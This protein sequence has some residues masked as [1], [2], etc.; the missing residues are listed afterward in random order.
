[1]ASR[2][3]AWDG[4]VQFPSDSE[5]DEDIETTSEKEKKEIK[6]EKTKRTEV[7]EEEK[8]EKEKKKERKM[9]TPE[10]QNEETDNE[11]P[12]KEKKK[13][14]K[15]EKVEKQNEET[16][17]EKPE[18]EKKKKEKIT[19]KTEKQNKETEKEKLE[20]EKKKA[21]KTEKPEEQD[22]GEKEK[23]EKEK[24]KKEKKVENQN[25]VTGKAKTEKEKMKTSA[26]VQ[27]VPDDLK[28]AIETIVYNRLFPDLMVLFTNRFCVE[29]ASIVMGRSAQE[30]ILNRKSEVHKKF[31]EFCISR[32]CVDEIDCLDALM[33]LLDYKNDYD[34]F[35]NRFHGIWEAYFNHDGKVNLDDEIF[36]VLKKHHDIYGDMDDKKETPEKLKTEKKKE[37]P[38]K[39]K[40]AKEKKPEKLENQHEETGKAKKEKEKDDDDDEK[41]DKKK[42]KED[43]GKKEKKAE[44]PENGD[45]EKKKT[46]APDDLLRAID[47]VIHDNLVPVLADKFPSFADGNKRVA[48]GETFEECMVRTHEDK[49]LKKELIEFYE[50]RKCGNELACLYAL[51][52]L[53]EDDKDNSDAFING[54]HAIWEKFF[55][56]GLEIGRNQ[57]LDACHMKYCT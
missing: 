52:K 48:K 41:T 51:N 47:D 42:K 36:A 33:E 5:N 17:N 20:K 56:S 40:K 35:M 21:K 2:R 13:E 14:R 6:Y 32:L 11:K 22:E 27:P 43:K 12:E 10:K 29:F 8:P 4:E 1:M 57:N 38:E 39:E 15:M 44:K 23:P 31:R 37:K 19:E 50:K 18:K 34:A 55:K 49:K 45:T 7:T 30:C 26:N 25:E 53:L 46:P 3:Y 16:D 54:F 24:K 28:S 9:E